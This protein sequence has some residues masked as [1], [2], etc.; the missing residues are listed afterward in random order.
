[1]RPPGAPGL[2]DGLF[3]PTSK[4]QRVTDFLNLVRDLF[5][6]ADTDSSSKVLPRAQRIWYGID[7]SYWRREVTVRTET[8]SCRAPIDP[9][10]FGEVVAVR[11]LPNGDPIRLD[12]LCEPRTAVPE[13]T[14]TIGS[15]RTSNIVIRKEEDRGVSS[16]HFVL[17]RDDGRTRLEDRSKNGTWIGR[18][19]IRNNEVDVFPGQVVDFGRHTQLLLCNEMLEKCPANLLATTL[20]G[21]CEVAKIRYR[22]LG[23]VSFF[24]GVP[25]ATLKKWFRSRRWAKKR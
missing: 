25:Y 20:D 7:M 8:V 15:R 5:G 23:I 6:P 14:I 19:W 10:Q 12:S 9:D 4:Y 3:L 22:R 1:M 13:R 18:A 21:F 24:I 2:R 11:L 17:H 16:L